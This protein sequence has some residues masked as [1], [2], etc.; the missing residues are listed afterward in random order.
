M[1]NTQQE[2]LAAVALIDAN[3]LVIHDLS[4]Y[5]KI[6][7]EYISNNHN[8]DTWV[9]LKYAKMLQDLDYID[10]SKIES[11]LLSALQSDI[12]KDDISY[13]Y[14]GLLKLYAQR[15]QIDKYY[16]TY[17]EYTELKYDDALVKI[18]DDNFHKNLL[19][20][21]CTM[22]RSV[23]FQSINTSQC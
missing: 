2:L 13:C 4:K 17:N 3:K 16:Q 9:K 18:I 11:L 12:T 10:T 19:K 7:D 20:D 6:F 23:R 21:I 5:V 8:P 14:Y 15:Y 1:N 22:T